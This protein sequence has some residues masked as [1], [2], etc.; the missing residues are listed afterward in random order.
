MEVGKYVAAFFIVMLAYRIT[1]KTHHR[2]GYTTPLYQCFYIETGETTQVSV[3]ATRLGEAVEF[4]T[5]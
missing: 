5:I 2:G 1:Y 4:F 3:I